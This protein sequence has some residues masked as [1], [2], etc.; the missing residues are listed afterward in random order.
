MTGAAMP[1]EIWADLQE[2]AGEETELLRCWLAGMEG[3]GSADIQYANYM[4]HGEGDGHPDPRVGN[5]MYAGSQQWVWGDG[6]F[7]NGSN[8]VWGLCPIEGVITENGNAR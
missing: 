1:I 5:G 7:Y 3:S 4:D 6:M 2:D 8:G